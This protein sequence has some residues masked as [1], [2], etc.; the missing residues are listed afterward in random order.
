MS[1]GAKPPTM[2]ASIFM[3]AVV[4]RLDGDYEKALRS[5]DRM[6]TLNPDANASWPAIIGRASSPTSAALMKRSRNLRRAPQ[7]E[8][9]H[10]LI[11][12]FRARRLVLPR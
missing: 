7:I 1:C 2:R 10:P 3:R 6:M 8:P 11:K 4:A 5:F 9:D 12:T